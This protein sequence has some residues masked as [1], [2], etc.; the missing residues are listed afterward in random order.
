MSCRFEFNRDIILTELG[1]IFRSALDNA[2]GLLGHRLT[3]QPSRSRQRSGPQQIGCR[4]RPFGFVCYELRDGDPHGRIFQDA[5]DGILAV[6]GVGVQELIIGMTLTRQTAS[7]N[8]PKSPIRGSGR[9]AV[10]GCFASPRATASSNAPKRLGRAASN[11]GQNF[12]SAFRF[13]LLIGAKSGTRP[14]PSSRRAR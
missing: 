4:A 3:F 5:G 2:F 7:A 8:W 14:D 1:E 11:L 10:S 12:F 9:S 6:S 13:A